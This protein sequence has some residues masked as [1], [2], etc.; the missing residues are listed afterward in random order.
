ME[1]SIG[2]KGL[3]QTLGQVGL[4]LYGQSRSDLLCSNTNMGLGNFMLTFNPR[5][6]NPSSKD[7]A[8]KL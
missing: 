7:T 8:L 4:H 5:L 3:M 6:L 2:L 1:I